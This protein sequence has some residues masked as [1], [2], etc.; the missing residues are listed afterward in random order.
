MVTES[1]KEG[2]QYSYLNSQKLDGDWRSEQEVEVHT[3]GEVI[4]KDI[5]GPFIWQ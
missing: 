5:S 4:C 1:V 2:S 3:I